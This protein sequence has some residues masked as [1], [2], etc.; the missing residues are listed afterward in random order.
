MWKRWSG[1][2]AGRAGCGQPGSSEVGT[3]TGGAPRLA[4]RIDPIESARQVF[5]VPWR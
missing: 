4:A 2:S 1:G 5:P 3:R